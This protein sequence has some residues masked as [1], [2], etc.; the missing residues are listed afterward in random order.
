MVLKIDG[1]AGSQPLSLAYC[2]DS[3]DG[4][5]GE[6]LAREAG[7]SGVPPS[8]EETDG[9]ISIPSGG[10]VSECAASGDGGSNDP[11][12]KSWSMG[13]SESSVVTEIFA[14]ALF[15]NSCHTIALN[16]NARGRD[17]E[18]FSVSFLRRLFE[19]F[20]FSAQSG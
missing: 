3:E 20:G 6:P 16:L 4:Q 9:S 13:G 14:R 10:L 7:S 11:N 2:G 12:A 8:S 1:I 17:T 19:T 15:G 5:W 18:P